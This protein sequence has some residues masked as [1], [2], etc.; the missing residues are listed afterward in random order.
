MLLA[1][2]IKQSMQEHH[3][4]FETRFAVLDHL[5]AVNGNGIEIKNGYLC[6]WD[7]MDTTPKPLL[8]REE[9]IA[10][11]REDSQH[12]IDMIEKTIVS[13]EEYDEH[14]DLIQDFKQ[15]LDE[16]N[17]KDERTIERLCNIDEAY[18]IQPDFTNLNV[19]QWGSNKRYIP[20]YEFEHAKY[21]D[22]VEQLEYFR[23]CI[24]KADVK[25]IDG[26]NELSN[27]YARSVQSWKDNIDKVNA[28]IE[29]VKN[30]S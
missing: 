1:D 22:L 14:D 5:F 21:T 12:F 20:M 4:I 10:S 30:A 19:Y 11:V 16:R 23:D 6:D 3:T 26:G 28:F 18:K 9:I 17:E 29:K 15:K 27:Y 8:T 7:T 25:E 13:L 2:Y 24:V